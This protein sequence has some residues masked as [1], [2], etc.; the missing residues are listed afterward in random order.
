[1]DFLQWKTELQDYMHKKNLASK[2]AYFTEKAVSKIDSNFKGVEN[3]ATLDLPANVLDPIPVP[4]DLTELQL[5]RI[6]GQPVGL[7]SRALV[8]IAIDR[9]MRQS[10][11][12][13]EAGNIRTPLTVTGVDVSLQYFQKMPPL[14]NDTDTTPIM[15]AYPDLYTYV[16]CT[17]VALF[18]E[19]FESATAYMRLAAD[20]FRSAELKLWRY[21]AGPSPAIR[22]I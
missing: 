14:V 6:G 11:F 12:C 10:I 21:H 13:I 20:V 1:M 9:K 7:S 2:L 3:L 5:L 19:D 22:S 18:I 8:D 16:G 15:A 17:E 4:A